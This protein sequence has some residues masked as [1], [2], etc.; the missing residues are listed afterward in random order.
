[1]RSVDSTL[2]VLRIR[3]G[4]LTYVRESCYIGRPARSRPLACPGTDAN[5][6]TRGVVNPG[7]RPDGS[8]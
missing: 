5:S 8:P 7:P 1:M 4:G 2:G 3:C 6:A